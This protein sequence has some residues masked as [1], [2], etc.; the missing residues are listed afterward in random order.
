MSTRSDHEGM[1]PEAELNEEIMTDRAA[2][3]KA[4]ASKARQIL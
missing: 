3:A 2:T 1:G 4:A